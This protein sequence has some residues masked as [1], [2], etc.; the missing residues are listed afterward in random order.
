MTQNLRV[1]I[2]RLRSRN[3][4]WSPVVIYANFSTLL[5][6]IWTW[7]H[8]TT[9]WHETASQGTDFQSP[10]VTLLELGELD[11]TAV[12]GMPDHNRIKS[13]L[14]CFSN[15]RLLNLNSYQFIICKAP[16]LALSIRIKLKTTEKQFTG[17]LALFVLLIL[18][19]GWLT[20]P[21]VGCF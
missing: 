21:V 16:H 18:L 10:A 1:L 12:L 14:S 8:L 6:Q 2:G 7:K 20:M 3:F 17:G 4:R 5:R 11:E 19:A 9:A 15:L 13:S